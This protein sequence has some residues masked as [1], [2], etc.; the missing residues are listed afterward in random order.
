MLE[1]QK[2]L[3]E[4]VGISSESILKFLKRLDMQNIPMH[5]VQ[6]MRKGR[7]V[8][9][10]YYAPCRKGE[11]HRMFSVTKSFTSMAVGKLEEEGYISLD[12]PIIKYFPEFD[13]ENVHPWVRGTTIRNMLEM[14]TCHSF[15]TYKADFNKNWV[16]SFFAATPNHKPGTVFHYD[17]S[18]SH[19]LCALVE[20]LTGQPMLEYLKDKVLREIGFSEESY[21]LKD[22]FGTSMGGSGLMATPE[23]LLRFGIWLMQRGEINGKQLISRKY[24]EKATTCQ[25]ENMV[26]GPTVSECQ[27]YGYQIWMG[28]HESIMCL[29][30]GGQLVLC[31]PKQEL[32]CVTTADTQGIGGG[33][34]F[35]MDCLY[36]EILSRLSEVPLEINGL[37]GEDLQNYTKQMQIRPLSYVRGKKCTQIQN[38]KVNGRKY[39][40][41]DNLQGFQEMSLKVETSG[42]GVLTFVL[43][44]NSYHFNFGYEK[45][46][47]DCFP[48]HEMRCASSGMWLDENTFYIR[49]LLLDTACGSI[50]F[51]L[52]FGEDD[53]TVFMKKD[54]ELLFSEFTGHIYGKAA[55]S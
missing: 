21:I 42:E 3:P 32:L 28:Q 14:R 6:I 1:I 45:V 34:Q 16:E 55:E 33:N 12:D 9:E 30:M 29:G 4:E 51:Q 52:F 18:S 27:G 15:T 50:H 31:Y 48:I 44:G 46:Q 5:S 38:Q 22:P 8:F 2:A 7:L 54:D 25:V 49:T 20:K 53:L 37:D 39:A 43:K 10:G 23:D 17:T 40:F 36:E 26:K 19:T 35:I 13:S 24:L 11:L 47:T 41:E